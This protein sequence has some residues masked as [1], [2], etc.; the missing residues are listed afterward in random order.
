MPRRPLITEIS[1]AYCG[2]ILNPRGQ[3]ALLALSPR[4][5]AV[6]GVGCYLTGFRPAVLGPLIRPNF[7]PSS[8]SSYNSSSFCL[9]LFRNSRV[10]FPVFVRA[11]AQRRRPPSLNGP[12]P[13]GL[14][15]AHNVVP[16]TAGHRHLWPVFDAVA[17]QRSHSALPP[18]VRNSVTTY[19][20]DFCN[21]G[22]VGQMAFLI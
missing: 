13:A 6:L 18:R 8:S 22:V 16:L 4:F 17:W 2:W 9:C 1:E 20:V 3:S 14:W 5:I 19:L 10:S 21:V 12:R 11:R 7:R 15:F